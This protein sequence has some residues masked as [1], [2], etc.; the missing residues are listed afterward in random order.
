MIAPVKKAPQQIKNPNF[1]GNQMDL[2]NTMITT[3]R[4]FHDYWSKIMKAIQRQTEFKFT[5]KQFHA[6]KAIINI[7]REYALL[8]CSNKC[9]NGWSTVRKHFVRFEKWNTNYH[10][11]H[12]FISSYGGWLG[13][14]GVHLH[15]WSLKIFTDI[16]KA[17]GGFIVV[18]KKTMEL[19]NMIEAKIKVRF[20]YFGFIPALILITDE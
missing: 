12:T 11:A 1:Q 8:L 15:M 6:D 19:S 13:F 2:E 14:K 4:F 5:Y 10:V 17:C 7:A 16:G 3:R 20:N 18:A 9:D